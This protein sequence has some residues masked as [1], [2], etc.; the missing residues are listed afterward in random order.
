M[1]FSCPSV[2]LGRLKKKKLHHITSQVEKKKVFLPP[3][4][5]TLRNMHIHF[6]HAQ[7]CAPPIIHVCKYAYDKGGNT[8]SY[9]N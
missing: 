8:G 9:I 3:G 6:T 2:V 7:G 4:Y 1:A 5:I